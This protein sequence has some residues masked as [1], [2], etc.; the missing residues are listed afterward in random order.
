M[1]A[2]VLLWAGYTILAPY[3]GFRYRELWDWLALFGL[4]LPTLIVL[5]MRIRAPSRTRTLRYRVLRATLVI[6]LTAVLLW[7]G[8][9]IFAPYTGFRGRD[10]WDWL[11]LTYGGLAIALV[12]WLF[13][14]LV[15][16]D[17]D[18]GQ[19]S[20]MVMAVA[21]VGVIGGLFLISY[22]L[23]LALRKGSLDI[24]PALLAAGGGA[25]TAFLSN[26]VLQQLQ[27]RAQKEREEALE[28]RRTQEAALDAYAEKISDLVTDGGLQE[29]SSNLAAC[30]VAQ[31]LTAAILLRLD[32]EHKRRVLKLVHEMNLITKGKQNTLKLENAALYRANL[33]EISLRRVD[34][35]SVDL[36]A[37]N[38]IGADLSDSDFSD[39]DLRGADLRR[40]DLSGVCL[41]RANLLPHDEGNPERWR[42]HFLEKRLDL[43]EENLP[44]PEQ[45]TVTDLRE[46][47]LRKAQLCDAWLG[48]ADIR[49]ADLSGADLNGA[50]LSGA[51]LNRAIVTEEQLNECLSL[52]GA[53]MPDGQEYE[54]WLKDE[55][56]SR[57]GAEEN[58]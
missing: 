9:T 46:S 55:E 8:Y 30:Q 24:P 12:A 28:R 53:T 58:E 34:L 42:R 49:D 32:S 11:N 7:A 25:L 35:S 4:F 15:A 41:R 17:Q 38:L 29:K 47:L 54:D 52:K 27:A 44:P 33:R 6:M 18:E 45:L 31:A 36:R 26:Y 3:T 39:A 21:A 5:L 1:I 48:G 43:S 13:A 57:K 2:A 51:D 22:S 19:V 20:P 23:G 56:S 10:L 37:A 14:Q 40:A 16:R 50:D